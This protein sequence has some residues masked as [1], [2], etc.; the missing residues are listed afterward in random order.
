MANN[1]AEELGLRLFELCS[2]EENEPSIATM[3][4][5]ID[6]GANVNIKDEHGITTVLYC[7][8]SNSHLGAVKTLLAAGSIDKST[9]WGYG[10][11]FKI[12]CDNVCEEGCI[13]IVKELLAAHK[14]LN[15]TLNLPGFDINEYDREGD[16]TLMRCCSYNFNLEVIELLLS[17]PSIDI[18]LKSRDWTENT[19]LESGSSL[20]QDEVNEYEANEMRALFQG[21][22]LPSF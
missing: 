16:T 15:P 12:A 7:A 6:R 13:E 11:C 19:A 3:Q 18:H 21:E 20:G 1:N 10:M 14:R 22:L 9:F 17:I 8:V 4:S 5:L 2:D